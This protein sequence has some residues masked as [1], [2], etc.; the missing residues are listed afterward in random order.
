MAVG[1]GDDEFHGTDLQIEALLQTN[2]RQREN[3]DPGT[4]VESRKPKDYAGEF[5]DPF[6]VP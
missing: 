6:P 5:F 2:Y 3:L 4:V 1:A